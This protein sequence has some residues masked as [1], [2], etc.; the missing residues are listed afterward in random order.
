MIYGSFAQYYDE[1]FDNEMYHRWQQYVKSNTA[2]GSRLLD[3]A[4][5][6][7]RLGVLLAKDGY[8][9]TD[10]DLSDEML[11]LA[12]NHAQEAKVDLNL[13]QA[14]MMDLGDCGQFDVVTC[15]ADSLCYLDDLASV[16][17]TFQQV[18]AHLNEGG[19]FLF[20]V[21]TP[22]QTD[23]VYP[24]YMYNWQSADQQRFFMWSSYQDDDVAHGVIHELTFFARQANGQYERV[25]ETHFERSYQLTELLASLKTAG[26]V[27]VEVT[28]DFGQEKINPHTTRWFFKCQ[29]GD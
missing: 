5:G 20:D 17:Q 27:N 25:G 12:S 22:Y 9:V 3:L 4:G 21:I 19:Q 10:I 28:S 23:E 26:F 6:A 2:S 15:F 29:V 18:H 16:Q 14:N 13:I 1:L 7:G 11:A 8:D 24:G